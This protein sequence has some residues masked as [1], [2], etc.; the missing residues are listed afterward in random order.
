MNI[1]QFKALVADHPEFI[2]VRVDDYRNQFVAVTK[3]PEAV[4]TYDCAAGTYSYSFNGAQ[5]TGKTIEEAQKAFDSAYDL[6]QRQYEL[7]LLG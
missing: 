1:H 5:G 3:K 7:S 4:L 2:E 6:I